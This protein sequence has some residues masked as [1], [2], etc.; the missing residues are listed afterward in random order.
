MPML[1][2]LLIAVLP[3][4]PALAMSEEIPLKYIAAISGHCESLA[5]NGEAVGECKDVTFQFV[6]KTNRTSFAFFPA[7]DQIVAFSGGVIQRT[8]P[9]LQRLKLTNMNV[10]LHQIAAEGFCEVRGDLDVEADISCEARTQGEAPVSYRA[11]FKSKGKPDIHN[12]E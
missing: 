8:A 5:M 9:D 11:I 3:L 4:I 7:R 12:A 1:R 6:Y 10:N 2:R